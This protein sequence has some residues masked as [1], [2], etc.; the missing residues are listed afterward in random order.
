[1][2]PTLPASRLTA[3]APCFSRVDRKPGFVRASHATIIYLGRTLL[4]GSS[5]L[6]E[7]QMWRTATPFC[8]AL[9]RMGFT[10]L[11]KSPW[12]P[13]SSYLTFSTL[14]RSHRGPF[15]GLF[16][17]A[18]SLILRSVG[19]TDHPVLQSPDFPLATSRQR[20]SDPLQ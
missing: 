7:S 6:P 12:A 19:V 20:S 4:Y 5:S 2:V 14:P 13:V 11:P 3:L 15:G 10:R 9:L 16:S 17:V 18:L 1:M 8:L